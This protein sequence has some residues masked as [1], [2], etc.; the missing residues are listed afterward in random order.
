[1]FS[2]SLMFS[3]ESKIGEHNLVGDS[4]AFVDK[5]LE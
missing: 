3:V 1:M 4:V 5:E 2:N